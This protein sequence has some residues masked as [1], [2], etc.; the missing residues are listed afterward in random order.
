MIGVAAREVMARVRHLQGDNQ[1]Y[2]IWITVGKHIRTE[3]RVDVS[4]EMFVLVISDFA[5]KI[6]IGGVTSVKVQILPAK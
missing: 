5:R 3:V 6:M 2:Q 1:P 4:E